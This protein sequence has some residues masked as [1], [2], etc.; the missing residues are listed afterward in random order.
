MAESGYTNC[1]CRDC[2]ETVISDDMARPDLCVDCL[3]AGCEK[4]CAACGTG[5]RECSNPNAYDSDPFNENPYNLS[6]GSMIDFG[7]YPYTPTNND[8]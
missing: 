7:D 5:D 1:G 8:N 4:Y 3:D 2:F 6:D